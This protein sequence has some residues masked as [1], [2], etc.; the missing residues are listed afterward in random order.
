M[1]GMD[2]KLKHLVFDYQASVRT[3]VEVMQRSGIP[4]PLTCEN[5]VETDIPKH[6]E[7][8][9][10]I[11][12][13]KHGHGCKVYLTTGPVDFD[14]GR[15]GEIDGF[16]VWR[17]VNFAG[18][19]LADYGFE[20]NAAV[21]ESFRAAVKS[22][23]LVSSGYILYYV[24]DS[25]R[26]L[27]VEVCNDFPN[28]SL[29]YCDKDAVLTLYA[30]CF[31]AA[32]LMRKNYEKLSH[33]LEKNKYLSQNDRVNFR[34]YFSSWLGYLGVTCEGFRNLSMRLL[35]KK[36]RPE[37][38]CELISKCDEIGRLLKRHAESLR[39]FRNNVFH[40]REDIRAILLF[41]ADDAGRLA[42]AGELH[43]TIA[44]FLSEYR[45]LCEV[46]Y[47]MHGRRS[48]SQI[49]GKYPRRR[50]TPLS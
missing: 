41:A 4:L 46:H 45:V 42:W 37:S 14:F 26:L 3:A 24:T 35:L 43:S 7:L 39:E 38:F 12:Y 10:G 50:K 28:D 1:G 44:E 23:S 11:R 15:L 21:E 29:P 47:V 8:E 27:A 34:I 16:D 32:D 31:L 2:K 36:N 25:V 40:L 49:G 17:L 30:N 20:T 22:G 48:E 33:K 5:W 19:K 18:S 6:G 13:F 9:D